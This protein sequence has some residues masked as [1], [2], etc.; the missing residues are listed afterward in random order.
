MPSSIAK[1]TKTGRRRRK[2]ARPRYDPNEFAVCE[3]EL[4]I[5]IS[6]KV[7]LVLPPCLQQGYRYVYPSVYASYAA[8]VAEEPEDASA[9]SMVSFPD[10]LSKGHETMAVSIAT[11]LAPTTPPMNITDA[12]IDEFMARVAARLVR[13]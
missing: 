8:V 13:D 5:P 6:M 4:L 12:S 10:S 3:A 11:H 9:V 1:R 2:R 7:P